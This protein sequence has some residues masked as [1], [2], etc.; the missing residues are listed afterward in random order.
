MQAE[1]FVE[2]T[3]SS[4]DHYWYQIFSMMDAFDGQKHMLL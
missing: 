1:N 2:P 3:P 4:V